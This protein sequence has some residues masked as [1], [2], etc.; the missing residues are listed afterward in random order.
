MT[1][2]LIIDGAPL[3]PSPVGIAAHILAAALAS[4]RHV[5]VLAHRAR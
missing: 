2:T 3:S 4:G 5:S 1:Y